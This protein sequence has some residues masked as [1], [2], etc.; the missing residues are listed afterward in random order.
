MDENQEKLNELYDAI[1]N[2]NPNMTHQDFLSWVRQAHDFINGTSKR[3]CL[4][5][6]SRNKNRKH[7]LLTKPSDK[8]QMN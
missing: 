1:A 2:G 5:N 7:S 6:T 8:S 3:K 4:G